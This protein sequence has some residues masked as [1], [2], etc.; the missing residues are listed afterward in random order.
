MQKSRFAGCTVKKKRFSKFRWGEPH[1]EYRGNQPEDLILFSPKQ[2]KFPG[3]DGRQVSL[4]SLR[5][6]NATMLSCHRQ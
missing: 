4:T 2:L 1:S 6:H 3:R 5:R